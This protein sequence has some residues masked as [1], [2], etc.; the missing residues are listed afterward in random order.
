MTTILVMMRP[1]TRVFS[2]NDRENDDSTNEVNNSNAGSDLDRNL[3]VTA[4]L[5][6]EVT[7]GTLD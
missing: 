4:M 5:V 7:R 2:A 3:G 6:T 1:V